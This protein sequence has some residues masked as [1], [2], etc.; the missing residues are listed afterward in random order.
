[1]DWL[2]T[3]ELTAVVVLI[4]LVAPIL[5]LYARRHWLARQGGMFE[6]ALRRGPGSGPRAWSLGAAR[7]NGEHLEWFRAVSLSF[8]PRVRLRRSATAAVEAREPAGSE[9]LLFPPEQ[10][11]V[12]LESVADF[13]E[14]RVYD[15]A[16]HAGSATGLLAWL[17]ARPPSVDRFIS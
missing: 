4:A 8:R 7:Y 10:R 1:M 3:T 13:G 2:E 17:E 16:M 12:R 5:A 14:G 15:L 9:A 11:M 6:C